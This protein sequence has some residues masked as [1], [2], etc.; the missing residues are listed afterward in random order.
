MSDENQVLEK[1]VLTRL[2]H[3]NAIV[4]GMVL[5]LVFGLGIFLSTNFLLL[6]GGDVVGPH[7]ALLGQ[8][9]IGYEVTFLG[10]IIGLIYGLLIGFGTG[11]AFGLIYNWIAILRE[12]NNGS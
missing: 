5:G 2:I 7:L 12:R 11:Y 8:F 1:I 3:I 4:T 10:S 6:K 9:L